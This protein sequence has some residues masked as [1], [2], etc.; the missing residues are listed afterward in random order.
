[1]PDARL[2]AMLD[3]APARLPPPSPNDKPQTFAVPDARRSAWR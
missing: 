2:R 1:M 3:M